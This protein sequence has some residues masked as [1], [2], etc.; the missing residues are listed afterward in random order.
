MSDNNQRETAGKQLKIVFYLSFLWHGPVTLLSETNYVRCLSSSLSNCL[1]CCGSVERRSFILLS[2]PICPQGFCSSV[3]E[4]GPLLCRS[5]SPRTSSH[6]VSACGGVGEMERACPCLCAVMTVCVGS[7]TWFMHI[8]V[9]ICVHASMCACECVISHPGIAADC[10][11]VPHTAGSW[12]I[13]HATHSF[14]STLS[15]NH[16]TFCPISKNY[17]C[18]A[19][20]IGKI[21]NEL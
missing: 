21:M 2:T 7:S 19:S 5:F 15:A 14:P 17:L 3:A 16:N 9:V 20:C 1:C 6:Y 10:A 4:T 11:R 13:D 12:L 8:Y 18:R